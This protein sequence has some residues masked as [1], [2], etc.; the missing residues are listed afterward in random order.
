MCRLFYF[1]LFVT[2][3][4][5]GST[6]TEESRLASTHQQELGGDGR[7]VGATG[8]R[9]AVR[10]SPARSAVRDTRVCTV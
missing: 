2:M 9:E 7:S 4:E 10:S 3:E 6:L 8:G 1:D 5:T